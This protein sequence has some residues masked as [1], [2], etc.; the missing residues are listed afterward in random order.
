MRDYR[1]KIKSPEE[2]AVILANLKADGGTVV[3]C[4][5]AFDLLHRGHLHQF[6]QA[7]REGDLLVVSVTSDRFVNK[8]PNRPVFPLQVR[9]E[10]IAALECV[11]YVTFSDAA[12]SEEV[13]LILK[14]SV[15]IKGQAYEDA[16]RDRSG[17]ITL[18]HRA[19]ESVG[20]RIHFTNELP[21]HSTP[22]LNSFVDPYPESVLRFLEGFKRKF[23][24][25]RVMEHL[26]NLRGLRVLILGEA[27]I[28]QYD[29]GERMDGSPKGGVLPMRHLSTELFA[30]GS[31]ACANHVANFCS[32]VRL[33]ANLGFANSYEGF[34]R[35]HLSAN[36]QPSFLVRDGMPTIVKR[37]EVDRAY[38]TK[39]TETYFMDDTPLSLGEESTLLQLLGENIDETDLV[40]VVDYGHGLIT[41]RI[42]N[43]LEQEAPF[44][45]VNTQTNSA[46]KGY[47]V[48]HRYPR[49]DFVCVDHQEAR[50]TL[51][52]KHSDIG[53]IATRIQNDL[54][55]GTVAVTLGH[56]G[57]LVRN[58]DTAV[59]TPVFSK[60]VVDTIGAGDAFLSVTAPCVFNNV[61]LEVTALLGNATGA[62]ATTYL[63]NKES[64]TAT[65]LRNFVTSLLG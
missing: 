58:T 19:V 5:G 60:K 65:M 26:D 33:V 14:P 43:F 44:L 2:L 9:M 21:I 11:D 30:G 56:K 57:S 36:V 53:E 12:S 39:V 59:V 61:P 52:D 25:D 64:V 20:G 38:L 29:F 55:A 28:D 51:R 18:E 3:Q 40:L 45:A 1:V 22:L 41:P 15:Y 7:C 17:K 34:I 4:H 8:G 35:E 27:I 23:P 37:R 49:A 46:N 50:L 54:K 24:V 48:I 16:S 6:E 42:V 63:G 62:L 31:L 13:I 47:H 32:N 10:M